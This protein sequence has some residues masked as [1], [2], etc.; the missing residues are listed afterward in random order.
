M[1][2]GRVR[3]HSLA[4]E[5]GAS[6]VLLLRASSV[7]VHAASSNTAVIDAAHA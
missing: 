5:A 7:R 6:L 2:R 3:A 1:H 4:P